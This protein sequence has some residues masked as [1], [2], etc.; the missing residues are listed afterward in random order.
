V[1]RVGRR[2]P[3]LP[4][5][6]DGGRAGDAAEKGDEAKAIHRPRRVDEGGLTL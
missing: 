2:Q 6:V 5:R 3:H 1:G 4:L